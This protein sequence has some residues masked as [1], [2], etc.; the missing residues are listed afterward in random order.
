M[1]TQKELWNLFSSGLCGVIF[2]IFTP[3]FYP[4]SQRASP[5]VKNNGT[6]FGFWPTGDLD[7]DFR[8]SFSKFKDEVAI[9]H[10]KDPKFCDHRPKKPYIIS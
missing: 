6:I 3:V 10:R 4:K 9:S 2:K 5:N 8:C 7:F 1:K